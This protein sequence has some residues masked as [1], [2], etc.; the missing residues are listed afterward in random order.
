MDLRSAFIPIQ[1]PDNPKSIMSS[2]LFRPSL[3]HFTRL[4]HFVASNSHF[5]Q[6][7]RSINMSV[8]PVYTDKCY[9]R[10]FIIWFDS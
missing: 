7:R 4:Q 8:K 10:R 9:K 1:F 5:Q 6:P 3:H 2:K